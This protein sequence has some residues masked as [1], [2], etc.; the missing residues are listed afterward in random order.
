MNRSRPS[1]R[2]R[3]GPAA[4]RDSLADGDSLRRTDTT[5][6]SRAAMAGHQAAAALIPPEAASASSGPETTAEDPIFPIIAAY[7]QAVAE[8]MAFLE[9]ARDDDPRKLE[10]ID[11]EFEAFDKL[12]TTTPTTVAGVAALIDQ[13]AITPY[14]DEGH[15]CAQS[16][17]ERPSISTGIART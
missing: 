1:A 9:E 3:Y 17:I 2:S 4:G 7:K 16:V 10:M 6:T 11:R 15:N 13:L 5:L 12:F 8:R 14:N